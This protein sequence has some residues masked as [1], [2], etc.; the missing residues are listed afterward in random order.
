MDRGDDA[1]GGVR[2]EETVQFFGGLRRFFVAHSSFLPSPT[3]YDTIVIR[4]EIMHMHYVIP[5]PSPASRH[6][7]SRNFVFFPSV[8]ISPWIVCVVVIAPPCMTTPV[9]T[10]SSTPLHAHVVLTLSPRPR[11]LAL[12][13]RIHTS[14]I[15]IARNR[16]TH[17]E[18]SP[19]PYPSPS[20]TSTTDTLHKE[21]RFLFFFFG[22]P[23]RFSSLDYFCCGPS[24]NKLFRLGRF[25]RLF[26]GATPPGFLFYVSSLILVELGFFL[27]RVFL[28]VLQHAT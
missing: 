17:P 22:P 24:F 18:V 27:F 8:H 19:A 2:A 10:S 23:V 6:L 4:A 11:S 15:F 14:T 3:T 16:R 1:R 26:D 9:A 7:G 20:K 25:S 28:V 12:I 5:L 13:K 21:Q